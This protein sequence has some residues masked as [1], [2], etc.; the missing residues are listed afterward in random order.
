MRAGDVCSGPGGKAILTAQSDAVCTGDSGRSGV[1]GA[2]VQSLAVDGAK[3]FGVETAEGRMIPTDE[4][5]ASM[6]K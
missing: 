1:A 4:E 6:L 3:E 2:M 5:W